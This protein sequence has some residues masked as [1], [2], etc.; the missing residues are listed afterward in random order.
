MTGERADDL[1]GDVSGI[2]DDS[3]AR[4]RVEL[5]REID[6]V[7]N[8]IEKTSG[9]R[10]DLDKA[11]KRYVRKAELSSTLKAE[12]DAIRIHVV[13]TRL[14]VLT[15]GW[16]LVCRTICWEDLPAWVQD[17]YAKANACDL[18]WLRKRTCND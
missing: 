15:E 5:V 11:V 9:H 6:D 17:W 1:W 4:I 16:G 10:F 13:C 14:F 2:V 7:V 3:D 12:R 18:A 8:A